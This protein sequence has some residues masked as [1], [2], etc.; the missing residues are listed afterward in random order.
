MCYT[1][2]NAVGGFLFNIGS[3]TGCCLCAQVGMR[4]KI[5]GVSLGKGQGALAA[6]LIE[7][8]KVRGKWVLLQ[9]RTSISL[10]TKMRTSTLLSYRL[11][12]AKDWLVFLWRRIATL[13]SAGWRSWSES[14]RR[15]SPRR[16]PRTSDYGLL[17]Y[18]LPT[19]QCPCCRLSQFLVL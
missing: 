19:S 12:L 3:V 4:T 14:L 5:D 17:V 1:N 7:E 16:P 11:S 2:V 8:A 6:K 15:L 13:R 9:V 18:Q 10:S